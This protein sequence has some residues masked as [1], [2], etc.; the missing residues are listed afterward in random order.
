[1][2]V[3]LRELEERARIWME[4]HADTR[5]AQVLL[6]VVSFFEATVVPLPPST[7]LMGMVVLGK[8]HRWLYL[9]SLTTVTSVL[10][11]L[12]GYIIGSALYDTV[13]VW[14]IERYDLFEELEHVGELFRKNA[15]VAVFVGA[16][17]PIPYK[18]FT[19][20]GGFFSVSVWTFIVASALGRGIRFY[21]LAY[22]AH[23][24]GERVA[25]RVLRYMT[26]TLIAGFAML[27]LIAVWASV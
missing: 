12:F 10:G 18:V 15:F 1:M 11:G 3:H 19:I 4:T 2:I 16:F 23:I 7:L 20:G 9:A 27:I 5:T 13:G 21:A 17:T 26:L 22:L 25:K 14:I 8:R 6:A 24:F